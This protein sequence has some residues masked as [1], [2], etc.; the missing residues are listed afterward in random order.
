MHSVQHSFETSAVMTDQHR[1]ELIV[2][3][4]FGHRG[5]A[6]GKLEKP[7]DGRSTGW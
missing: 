7:F 4:L 5:L 2:A 6:E 3:A 1:V